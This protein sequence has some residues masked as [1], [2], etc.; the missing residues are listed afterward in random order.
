MRK[1]AYLRVRIAK[2]CTVCQEVLNEIDA[3]IQKG[4]VIILKPD[5]T[6]SGIL[7]RYHLM[8]IHETRIDY[9][10]A[11]KDYELDHPDD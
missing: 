1:R 5:Y 6:A 3:E 7:S 8:V 9:E 4:K 11:Q 2:E 10:Q